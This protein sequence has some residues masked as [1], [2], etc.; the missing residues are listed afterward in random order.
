MIVRSGGF[1]IPEEHLQ[2]RVHYN[3]RKED[4]QVQ[5]A[6]GQRDKILN[7]LGIAG[8]EYARKDGLMHGEM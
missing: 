2:K 1:K 8:L 4:T 6:V 7:D 3:E 5:Q